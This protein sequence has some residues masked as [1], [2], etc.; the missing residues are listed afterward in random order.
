MI[1]RPMLAD[2]LEDIKGLKFPVLVSPKL[3]GFRCIKVGG[4]ALSRSFKPIANNF[5]RSMIEKYLCDGVDGELMLKDEKATFAD[6]SSALRKYEGSPNFV[7]NAFDLVEGDLSK[8]FPERLDALE[9]YVSGLNDC[10]GDAGSIIKV[11]EH[12]LIENLDELLEYEAEVLAMGYE[13]VMIRSVTGPYKCGRSTVKEG[14]LLKLK[15]FV[16]AEAEVIGLVEQMKNNNA[17]EVSE[18]GLTKRATKKENLVPANTLGAFQV[19][20]IK[21]GVEFEI[22]TGDGLTQELRK[23]IWDNQS[24]YIGEIIKY[25]SQPTGVKEKPRFPVWL[26]FRAPEDM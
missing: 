20:D 11:V 14:Y 17:K 2:T 18:I 3:D 8:P 9:R 21:T 26:G 7:F 24:K 4:K 15:R 5:V 13:G 6:I 10:L 23:E 12:T 16:D 1:T 19:R 22:G 25:K